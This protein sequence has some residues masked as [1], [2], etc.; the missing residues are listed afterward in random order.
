MSCGTCLIP[1]SGTYNSWHGVQMHQLMKPRR[2]I[3][4]YFTTNWSG[5]SEV[6]RKIGPVA[7]YDPNSDYCNLK[8]N[9][10]VRKRS[11]HRY[12]CGSKYR[13]VAVRFT[14]VD[15]YVC[16]T[17]FSL[18]ARR[19]SR[20]PANIRSTTE[21]HQLVGPFCS[22]LSNLNINFYVY[23]LKIPLWRRYMNRVLFIFV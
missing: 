8:T 1:L 10:L 7:M 18:R 6:I 2:T 23:T 15:K 4:F 22:L 14:Y 20:T 13:Y 21:T 17:L 9:S 12:L 3:S 19:G 16:E 11:K 5:K